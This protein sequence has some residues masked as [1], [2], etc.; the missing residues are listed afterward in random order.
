VAGVAL[1]TKYTALLLPGVFCFYALCLAL[2]S[3]PML[4]RQRW[5]YLGYALLASTIAGGIFVGW[6]AWLAWAHPANGSHFLFHLRAN[7]HDPMLLRMLDQLSALPGLLGSI[8]AGIGLL[9]L[10]VLS[11]R[12]MTVGIAIGWLLLTYGVILCVGARFMARAHVHLLPG[13]PP[14]RLDGPFP[15]EA[16]LFSSLGMGVAGTLVVVCWRLLRATHGWPGLRRLH[17]NQAMDWFLVGW[18]VIELAGYLGLS[19]FPA[20]RR[21]MG[22]AIVATLVI[23]RFA[24][25]APASVSMRRL[26]WAAAGVNIALGVVYGVVDFR[27]AGATQFAAE[28][29][30]AWIAAQHEP[31]KVWYAGH[32]GFQFYAEQAGMEPLDPGHTWLAQGDWVVL[33]DSGIVQQTIVPRQDCLQLRHIVQKNSFAPVSTMSREFGGY[34]GTSTGAALLHQDNPRVSVRIYRVTRSH[35]CQ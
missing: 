22:L 16:V 27:L 31:G 21:C 25:R 32:W 4:S 6:E 35:R 1:Q 33:P 7:S 20:A 26:I 34:H 12:R 2:V 17:V 28:D 13:T 24:S 23:G 29:A 8:G 11:Q 18:L 19:P 9:A 5:T 14:M 15:L 10:A 30:G 3:T